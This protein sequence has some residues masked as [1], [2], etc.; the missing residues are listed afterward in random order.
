MPSD[1]QCSAAC[2][3]EVRTEV[4]VLNN[5]RATARIQLLEEEV[6]KLVSENSRLKRRLRRAEINKEGIIKD[7][8]AQLDRA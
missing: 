8:K 7:L 1:C 4:K 3:T 5:K 2:H 6:G